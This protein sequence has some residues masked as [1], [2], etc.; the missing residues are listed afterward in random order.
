M[1]YRW[2]GEGNREELGETKHPARRMFDA[3]KCMLQL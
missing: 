3:D 2:R 1:R